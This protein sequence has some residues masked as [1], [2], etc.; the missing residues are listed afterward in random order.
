M[1]NKRMRR[2]SFIY[3]LCSVLMFVF[4]ILSKAPFFI[5]FFI[6]TLL[7]GI[8]FYKK[9]DKIIQF[10][11]T[12]EEILYH[13]KLNHGSK[14]FN[15]FYNL[16]LK[17][18]FKKM[19]ISDIKNVERSSS[20]AL[21]HN[22]YIIDFNNTKTQLLLDENKSQLDEIYR[23]LKQVIKESAKHKEKTETFEIENKTLSKK[24]VVEE[25]NNKTITTTYTTFNND[26]NIKGKELL[27]SETIVAILIWMKKVQNTIHIDNLLHDFIQPDSENFEKLTAVVEMM[28]QNTIEQSQNFIREKFEE[29]KKE[30]TDKAINYIFTTTLSTTKKLFVLDRTLEAFFK[31][32]LISSGYGELS[33]DAKIAQLRS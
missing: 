7:L 6:V 31:E 25:K 27:I 21:G 22:L 17:N 9:T 4:F 12:P 20:F 2:T 16:F 19:K 3:I 26:P 10:E 8:Y 24:I 18:D 11:I 29:C 15:D 5:I 28:N 30:Y 13:P 23:D 33:L 14:K 32:L 1:S